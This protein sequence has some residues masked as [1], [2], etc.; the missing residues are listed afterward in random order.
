MKHNRFTFASTTPE[1]GGFWE[2][3]LSKV[4]FKNVAIL[5]R[6]HIKSFKDFKIWTFIDI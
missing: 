1:Y 6:P 4:G 3:A 5:P 2:E